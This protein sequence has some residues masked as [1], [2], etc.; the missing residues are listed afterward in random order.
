MS[1]FEGHAYFEGGEARRAVSNVQLQ[2]VNS[3]GII[4]ASVRT[5]Y[6]G[7]FFIERIPPGEYRIRIDPDQA[8]KLNIRLVGEVPVTATPEGG[9]VGKLSVNIARRGAAPSK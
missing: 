3:K 4:V 5:E 1:E 2:L 6:D 8:A 7:Y 9:L